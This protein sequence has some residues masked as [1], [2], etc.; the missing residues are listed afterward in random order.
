M[1]QILVSDRNIEALNFA[2]NGRREP[3]PDLPVPSWVSDWKRSSQSG[4]Y[5]KT[6]TAATTQPASLLSVPEHPNLLFV[7]GWTR[8]AIH[9]LSDVLEVSGSS[10]SPLDLSSLKT[11]HNT[12]K[13]MT[14]D[15]ATSYPADQRFEVYIRTMIGDRSSSS[16]DDD[17]FVTPPTTSKCTEMHT[18]FLR[19][20]NESTTTTKNLAEILDMYNSTSSPFRQLLNNSLGDGTSNDK[21]PP[22]IEKLEEYMQTSYQVAQSALEFLALSRHVFRNRFCI[23]EQ[24]RT[25]V[26]PP[27]TK[28]GDII[29]LLAGARMPFVL[30]PRG[31]VF[32]LLGCCYVHG[33]MEGG[34]AGAFEDKWKVFGLR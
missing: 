17:D 8:D 6:Y 20:C 25:A 30:R 7:K 18:N 1:R 3:D 2:G 15:H 9:L 34:G 14:I 26:V 4:L 12:A 5:N 32:E 31:K 23:T 16:A 13:S 10:A 33:L 11:W 29:V 19:Y 22:V 28:A 21:I 24:G 27:E